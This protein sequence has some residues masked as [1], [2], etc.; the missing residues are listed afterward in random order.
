[1]NADQCRGEGVRR[2]RRN[3]E[4]IGK[5]KAK[6]L[7]AVLEDRAAKEIAVIVGVSA[8]GVCK[9]ARVLGFRMMYVTA[10]ER[11]YLLT[12]RKKFAGGAAA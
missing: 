4:I 2:H 8:S 3:P 5:L 12:A 9:W 11:E 7:R 6:I 1:M 10:A